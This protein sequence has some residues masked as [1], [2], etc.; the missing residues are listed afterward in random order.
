MRARRIKDA[1]KA[2]LVHPL[3]P[4]STPKPKIGAK[5]RNQTNIGKE[6]GEDAVGDT[7]HNDETAYSATNRISNLL[8]VRK[9]TPSNK[10]IL[11]TF[12]QCSGERSRRFSP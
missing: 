12:H 3:P 10:I 8:V 2:L 5:K 7:I 9:T 1:K 6:G 4:Q 11:A